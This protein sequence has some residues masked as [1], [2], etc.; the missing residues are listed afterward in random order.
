MTA[1]VT[2]RY[3]IAVSA[4]LLAL[5]LGFASPDGNAASPS[6][7]YQRQE[8]AGLILPTSSIARDVPAR[9]VVT[10]FTGSREGRNVQLEWVCAREINNRGF[11]VQRASSLSRGWETLT[12]VPG[13]GTSGL[14]QTY[15]F[16]DRNAPPEDVRYMLR[17]LGED[18]VIQY[19]QIITVPAGSMLRSFI[20]EPLEKQDEKIFRSSVELTKGGVTALSVIDHKGYT[21][22]RVMGA[23]RLEPGR[24]EFVIDCSNVPGGSYQLLLHT[25]EGRYSRKLHVP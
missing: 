3:K 19:S 14:E 22:L 24:H 9:A 8:A 11:E 12:F 6:T 23:T 2:H 20:I 10:D 16:T 4:L 25:P 1:S 13:F 7:D 15:R 5:P 17:I 21:L 18:G